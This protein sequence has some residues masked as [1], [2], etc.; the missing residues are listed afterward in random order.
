[1]SFSFTV[2]TVTSHYFFYRTAVNTALPSS[3]LACQSLVGRTMPR[4]LQKSRLTVCDE[5]RPAGNAKRRNTT[6]QNWWKRT[7]VLMPYRRRMAISRRATDVRVYKT[8]SRV[9]LENASRRFLSSSA[10]CSSRPFF[11]SLGLSYRHPSTTR[12]NATDNSIVHVR[13]TT[14]FQQSNVM[15]RLDRF[16]LIQYASYTETARKTPS[17]I[18]LRMS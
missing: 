3:T 13:G 5:W 2:P 10:P 6:G 9:P 17:G 15:W 14:P 1:M 7:W 16:T 4:R 18:V 8:V 11:S 12:P